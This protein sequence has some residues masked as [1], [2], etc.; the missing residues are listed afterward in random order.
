MK[1]RTS[2]QFYV[3]LALDENLSRLSSLCGGLSNQR[4]Q[5]V[6]DHRLWPIKIALSLFGMNARFAYPVRI[7]PLLDSASKNLSNDISTI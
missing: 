4:A 6:S 5:N 2:I 1:Y 7:A 3:N